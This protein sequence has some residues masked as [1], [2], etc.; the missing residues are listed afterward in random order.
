MK[1]SLNIFLET[2]LLEQQQ[3][4]LFRYFHARQNTFTSTA[5]YENKEYLAFT[6]N[7]YLGLSHHPAIKNAAQHAME[8]Y[9]V[10]STA[11]HS[12]GGH[13]H[14]H[15]E[16]EQAL[17]QSTQR[18]S[19]LVFSTGY[20][21]NLGVI[22]ALVN[23][24]DRVFADRLVHA[25][26][27]DGAHLSCAPLIR[28]HHNNIS[29]LKLKLARYDQ[30]HKLI[31][32]ESVFSMDGDIAPLHELIAV[33]QEH[34]AWLMIDDAHGFGVLGKQGGGCCE[35]FN[36][37]A[38]DVP[39]LVGTLSKAIGCFGGFVAGS[40][41]L[42]ESVRQFARPYLFTTALPPLLAQ[43]GL[44]SLEIVKTETWRREYLQ[45]LIAY[46]RTRA[47]ELNFPLMPSN[48]PIQPIVLGD[49]EKVMKI[50]NHLRER[51]ILVA[52]IRP[53][54]VPAQTARL[55]ISLNVG[56]SKQ[57]IDRLIDALKKEED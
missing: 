18:E 21:T 49:N 4:H 48:T 20:M 14:A 26:I 38:D 36:L 40:K 56:H 32:S 22:S 15:D 51:G 23:A 42:I 13:C 31:V 1:K 50:Q 53:P 37:T 27:I 9:G 41:T 6:N 55:R 52:A 3:Q 16:L 25:S 24:E 33:A 10:G 5:Q 2:K 45:D 12:I 30:G 43:A 34:Q 46:F 47:A 8:Q 19:A 57:D 29:H 11:A 7:D 39:I 28:Y 35:Q 17:A 44:T 54:T